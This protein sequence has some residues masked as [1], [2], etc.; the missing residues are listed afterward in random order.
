MQECEDSPGVVGVTSDGDKGPKCGLHCDSSAIQQP[1][2]SLRSLQGGFFTFAT[3][4]LVNLKHAP[5]W[6]REHLQKLF[7]H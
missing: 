2:L 1:L 6:T 7:C 3:Y 5:G 4:D